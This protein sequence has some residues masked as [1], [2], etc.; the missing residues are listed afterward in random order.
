ML[1]L[2]IEKVDRLQSEFEHLGGEGGLTLSEFVST[3]K[4]CLT[5]GRVLDEQ[6]EARLVSKLIETFATIDIN[7]DGSLEWTEFTSF[8][9]EMGIASHEHKPDAIQFYQY[10]GTFTHGSQRLDIA[11]V[12]SIELKRLSNLQLLTHNPRITLTSATDLLF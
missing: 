5:E 8:I 4:T 3:M 2:N 12:R 11:K 6:E 9:I 10:T 1:N 7:G